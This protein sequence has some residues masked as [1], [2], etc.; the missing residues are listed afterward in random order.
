MIELVL[1]GVAKTDHHLADTLDEHR[2]LDGEESH[3]RSGAQIELLLALLAQQVTHSNGDIA[4]INIHRA[5]L[6][7]TV[8]DG[9]MRR[10]VIELGPVRERDTATGLFFVEE[11][12]DQ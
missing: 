8:T 12:F 6:L 5:R 2:V 7:A 11:G 3:G 10:D 4:E 1:C 9:A